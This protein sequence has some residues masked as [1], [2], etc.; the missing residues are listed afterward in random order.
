MNMGLLSF[1]V[2]ETQLVHERKRYIIQRVAQQMG[3]SEQMALS[4]L[5]FWDDDAIATFHVGND[6]DRRTL[7]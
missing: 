2:A 7:H 4:H 6:I 5:R 3:W 1:D